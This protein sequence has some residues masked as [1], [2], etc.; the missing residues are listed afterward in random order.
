MLK[1]PF[2]CQKWP[3]LPHLIPRH[4][5][6]CLNSIVNADDY[7]PD[8]PESKFQQLPEGCTV[9]DSS[10]YDVG[11]C[12]SLACRGESVSNETCGEVQT[13]CCAGMLTVYI[14]HSLFEQPLKLD[15]RLVFELV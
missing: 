12:K 7:C 14:F 11:K 3:H 15:V 13:Y 6:V 8:T 10:V 1:A 4:D 2:S 5:S 9:N